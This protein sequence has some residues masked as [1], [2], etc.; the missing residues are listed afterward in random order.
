MPTSSPDDEVV[1]EV[2]EKIG[3]TLEY[4]K[5]DENIFVMEDWKPVVGKGREGQHVRE[6]GLGVWNERVDR[7]VEF[8][9]EHNL[10]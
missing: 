4:V 8:C 1:E 5:A 3:D 9:A 2:Y 7:L 10:S 6:H